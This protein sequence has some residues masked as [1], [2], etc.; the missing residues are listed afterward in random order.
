MCLFAFMRFIAAVYVNMH[1]FRIC[2]AHLYVCVWDRPA[3][4]VMGNG[5]LCLIFICTNSIVFYHEWTINGCECI[6]YPLAL[7]AQGEHLIRAVIKVKLKL[8]SSHSMGSHNFIHFSNV[9]MWRHV[10]FA[11]FFLPL[12]LLRIL[13][14]M[15]KSIKWNSSHGNNNNNNNEWIP[16]QQ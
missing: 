9:Q 13:I 12:L 2:R 7:T 5:F 10:K 6:S 16:A 11:G 4:C 8:I 15:Q 3:T 14:I 1:M